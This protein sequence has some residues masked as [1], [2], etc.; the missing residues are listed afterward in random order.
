MKEHSP[1]GFRES[2][3]QVRFGRTGTKGQTTCAACRHFLDD[4]AE[5]ERV[6]VGIGALSSAYGSTRGRAGICR[7]DDSF[8]DPLPACSE[9]ET[10]GEGE[11][12]S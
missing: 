10:L 4:P 12:G 2:R 7:K 9:F 11:K 1:T 3:P 6:F 5:L 8:H